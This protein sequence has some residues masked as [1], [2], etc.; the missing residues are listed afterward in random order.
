MVGV[1]HIFL[2][3][4]FTAVSIV[5][6][7]E[8]GNSIAIFHSL[9]LIRYLDAAECLAILLF[10]PRLFMVLIINRSFMHPERW[11]CRSTPSCHIPGGTT[12]C[13][14]NFCSELELGRERP[15]YAIVDK[16]CCYIHTVCMTSEHL[17][18]SKLTQGLS[19]KSAVEVL[20]YSERIHVNPFL[21]VFSLYASTRSPSFDPFGYIASRYGE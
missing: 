14:I 4:K 16:T 8:H 7:P 19:Y 6:D 17:Q 9:L 13:T 15:W 10:F 11:G 3:L 20:S 1:S 12:N 21:F 18:V 2:R 5:L